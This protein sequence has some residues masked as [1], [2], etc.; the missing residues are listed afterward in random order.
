LG[1]DTQHPWRTVSGGSR[2]YVE[3]LTKPYQELIRRDTAV[4]KIARSSQGTHILTEDGNVYE[5]DQVVIAAHGDQALGMLSDPSQL[6]QNVLSRI[7]YQK[8]EA[9]LHTDPQFMPKTRRCWAAW[10]YRISKGPDDKNRYSTHYWMNQLQGVSEREQYFV[11]INPAVSPKPESIKKSLSYEHP[12]FDLQAIEAQGQIPQLHQ[13]GAISRRYFCG[14][15]QRYG[16]HEDGL[17]SA[18][19]VCTQILGRDPW[20]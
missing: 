8:N 12:L 14:A 17:W 9:V 5:F 18:V 10:N 13:E 7:H 15:W 19:N 3:K 20:R 6:E 1:L 2:S 16:F 4:Q 11:S